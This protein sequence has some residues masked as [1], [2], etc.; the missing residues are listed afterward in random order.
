MKNRNTKLHDIKRIIKYKIVI[1]YLFYTIFQCY[2]KF[3]IL[4]HNE[5]N[6]YSYDLFKRL[7]LELRQIDT[8]K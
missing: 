7:E 5:E 1:A 3:R 6:V 4:L 2:I 8:N